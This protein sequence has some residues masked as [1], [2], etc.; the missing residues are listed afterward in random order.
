MHSMHIAHTMT[1]VGP[2][3]INM[4]QGLSPY[5]LFSIHFT[6]RLRSHNTRA[7][8]Y[9]FVW[10]SSGWTRGK[11]YDYYLW[12]S[13]FSSLFVA[14]DGL[15]L[16]PNVARYCWRIGGTGVGRSY[17]IIRWESQWFWYPITWNGHYPAESHFAPV[18]CRRLRFCTHLDLV[19][20]SLCAFP[21]FFG[22]L[23]R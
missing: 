5:K 11:W 14:F 18:P 19:L 16:C 12:L 4:I 7:A 3:G 17:I 13:I 21:L 22:S 20:G 23:A 1:S 10:L 15:C 2:F 6:G 8:S 9:H